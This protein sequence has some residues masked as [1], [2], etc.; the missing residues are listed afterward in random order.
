MRGEV[1][2]G[3]H[4]CLFDMGAKFFEAPSPP[5]ATIEN[6]SGIDWRLAQGVGRRRRALVFHHLPGPSASSAPP[7]ATHTSR[8]YSG[9]EITV[10]I[11]AASATKRYSVPN[12]P[13]RRRDSAARL[14]HDRGL[15]RTRK[16]PLKLAGMRDRAAAI[17][18]DMKCAHACLFSFCRSQRRARGSGSIPIISHDA[19]QRAV[20]HALPAK[21]RR[22]RLSKQNRAGFSS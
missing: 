5:V 2:S 16:I 11:S 15:P 12:V 9:R 14:G 18:P 8:Y 17:G 19:S 21:L 10:I 4:G 13:P 6:T 3:A 20:G 7:P 1:G 22:G